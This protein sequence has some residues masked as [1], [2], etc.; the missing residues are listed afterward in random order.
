MEL[1]DL[2]DGGIFLLALICD[3]LIFVP[4]AIILIIS[5][6]K[7]LKKAGCEGWECLIPIYG[8]YVLCT[9]V[10][11][12]DVNHF[13]LQLIPFINIYATIVTYIAVAKSFGKDRKSTRLNSS[14]G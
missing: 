6:W 10:A 2:N 11:G 4:M 5:H 1:F 3:F 14:H 8:T 7:V 9:K 12:K 13:I